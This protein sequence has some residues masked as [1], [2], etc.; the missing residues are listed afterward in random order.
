[1]TK[2]IFITSGKIKYK[3][4]G[5]SLYQSIRLTAQG[6]KFPGLEQNGVEEVLARVGDISS[7][8]PSAIFASTSE[9]CLDTARLIAGRLGTPVV[10][11]KNLLPLRFNL[12]DIFSEA[13]FERLGDRRFNV[14]R[15][16]FISMFFD[17]KLI[18]KH[19]DFLRKYKDFMNKV[20]NS[21][22]GQT[23]VAVSHA[24]LIKLFSIYYEL[25]NGM[26]VDKKKLVRLFEPKK[27]TMSRLEILEI[28]I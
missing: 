18:D 25:E 8:S 19:E 21:Y 27:E 26:F 12:E 3:F 10:K 22:E 28:A 6:I 13:E 14:L 7:E 11:S 20:K 4:A 24:Y 16:K 17:N 23:V 2:I 9:Q 1:M 5:K 15:E